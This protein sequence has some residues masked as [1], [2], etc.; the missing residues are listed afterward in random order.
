MVCLEVSKRAALQLHI[1]FFNISR[2]IFSPWWTFSVDATKGP[3]FF[4]CATFW[5]SLSSA[6]ISAKK[7]WSRPCFSILRGPPKLIVYSSIRTT[8]P[9]KLPIWLPC[10][11]LEHH[12]FFGVNDSFKAI[13]LDD[14][15]LSYFMFLF[16]SLRCFLNDLSVWNNRIFWVASF[17]WVARVAIS[18]RFS[19]SVPP[20]ALRQKL[21]YMDLQVRQKD[22]RAIKTC[23]ELE[24]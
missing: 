1:L 11:V 3:G 13:M 10:L 8:P 20:K 19:H 17:C 18:H 23:A 24:K 14:F 21:E 5:W 6:T 15:R 9:K 2:R 22:G 7:M 12:Q 4:C 16:S